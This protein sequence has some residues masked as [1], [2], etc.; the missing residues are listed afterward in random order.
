LFNSFKYSLSPAA[1]GAP[2]AAHKPG[3][4]HN[5]GAAHKRVFE[6]VGDTWWVPRIS[7]S[8]GL[9]VSLLAWVPPTA[10]GQAQYG[11]I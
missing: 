4:A 7:P 2:G 5:P 10:R 3:A 1:P 8:S 6:L 11:T 9:P